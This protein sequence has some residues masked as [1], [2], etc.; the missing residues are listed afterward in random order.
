M[1][2]DAYKSLALH[3]FT[4]E[5]LWDY[6]INNVLKKPPQEAY[7]KA[8]KTLVKKYKSLMPSLYV[9][10]YALSQNMPVAIG[11]AIY[12]NFT[13]LDQN[14]VVPYPQ[15]ALQGGHAL[16]IVA[17]DDETKLFKIL[18]GFKNGRM[19]KYRCDDVA[20][21]RLIL[22]RDTDQRHII[23][24]CTAGGEDDFIRACVK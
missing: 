18:A 9:I 2:R 24:L 4:S 6:D 7:D 22:R 15:G 21:L 16:L 3:G 17:F 14:F 19:F 8:D 5:Y 10:K 20:V 12:D 11:A 1:Y 13:N 23:S